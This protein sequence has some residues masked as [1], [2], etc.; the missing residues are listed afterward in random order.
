MIDYML[1]PLR[2]YADFSGRSRRMEFWSFALLN[3]IVYGIIMLLA[4]AMGGG[5]TELEQFESGNFASYSAVSSLVFGGVG[6]LL[7]IWW[8]GT[9]IPSVAVTVRRLHDRGMSGWWYLGFVVISILPLLGLIASFAF[10][11]ILCLPGT[12]GANRFGPDPKD[13]SDVAVFS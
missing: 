12:P 11:I 7:L 13:P 6:I 3:V 4:V 10:L 9:I 8:L 1:M 5:R 2:R